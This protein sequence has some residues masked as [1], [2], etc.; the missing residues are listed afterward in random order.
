MIL[1]TIVI[2]T[3]WNQHKNSQ[4]NTTGS[5]EINPC[6]YSKLIFHKEARIVNGEKEISSINGAGNLI[7]HAKE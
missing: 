7:S 6:I 4:W 2:K 5:P 3:V 1:Q